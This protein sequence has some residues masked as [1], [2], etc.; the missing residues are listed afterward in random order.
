MGGRFK[1]A[2]GFGFDKMMMA[3][4]VNNFQ[5]FWWSCF[6]IIRQNV[7]MATNA[8]LYCGLS[9]NKWI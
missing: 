8:I 3:V 2:G 9:P 1:R 4:T 7:N 5:N 6:L